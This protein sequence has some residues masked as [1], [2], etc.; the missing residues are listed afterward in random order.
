MAKRFTDTN[1]YKKPFIRSLP[2]AYKLLWDFLYHDCDHAGIWIVDFET[3][4]VFVGKD[5][6][7]EKDKAL[8]LFNT[9]EERVV[10]LEGGDKWFIPS[11]IDFQYGHLS[12]KNRAHNSVISMLKK[13]GL[14]DESLSVG[15]KG[16]SE[17][18]PLTSTL[19][20]AM[21]KD[22]EQEKDKEQDKIPAVEENSAIVPQMGIDFKEANPKYPFD[23]SVDFPSLL[24][25]AEKI[26][27]WEKLEGG[28]SKNRAIILTRWGEMI[29]HIKSDSF[30]SKYSITQINKHFQSIIQ[31]INA[32]GDQHGK[33]KKDY[34]HRP[35]ITVGTGTAGKL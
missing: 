29:S 18:K 30:L 28:V 21:D 16:K 4:Q 35:A 17:N 34:T 12:E 19:Q 7:I 23:Q 15:K 26:L 5:M 10:V 2:G 22:K 1:K 9:K 24:S 8:E 32:N 6:E 33:A 13:Y 3:A 27:R 14:I 25:I 31:S 20:G 11:F